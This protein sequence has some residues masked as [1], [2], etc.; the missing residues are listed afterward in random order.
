MKKR[1]GAPVIGIWALE[2][3]VKVL[4]FAALRETLK[5]AELNVSIS[6]TM[7]IDDFKKLVS[8]QLPDSGEMFARQDT[9]CSVNQNILSVNSAPPIK[10][11]DEV[12]FFPPVTGG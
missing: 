6:G 3:M 4:F 2:I 1:E 8:D 10:D 9:L 12:A 7:S 5:C 11:G